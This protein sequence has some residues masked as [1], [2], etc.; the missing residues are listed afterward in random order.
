MTIEEVLDPMEHFLRYVILVAH[1]RVQSH[2][3][4]R[5]ERNAPSPA[6]DTNSR[7]SRKLLRSIQDFFPAGLVWKGLLRYRYWTDYIGHDATTS[8]VLA[9]RDFRFRVAS[10]EYTTKNTS[11]PEVLYYWDEASCVN[12]VS[13]RA[14]PKRWSERL[15]RQYLPAQSQNVARRPSTDYRHGEQCLVESDCTDPWRRHTWF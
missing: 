2:G 5:Q 9:R 1:L 3:T 6:F 11:W 10:I 4:Y 14:M 13:L 7:Y 12:S 15:G 8:L